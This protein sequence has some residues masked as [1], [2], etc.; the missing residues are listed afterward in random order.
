MMEQRT[1][2][3]LDIDLVGYALGDIDA[4]ST[5]ELD[6]HL[7]Q[8]LLCRV[9]LNRIRR[10]GLDSG[11]AALPKLTYPEIA[12]SILEVV[13]GRQRPASYGSGQLWLA[14]SPL[15]MLVWVQA[16][17][18]TA[19]MATV[20]ASTLD[21]DAADHTSLIVDVPRLGR[22]AAIFAS[23]PGWI[24]LDRLDIFVDDVDVSD[25]IVQLQ[26]SI[27]QPIEHSDVGADATARSGARRPQ[28][29]EALLRVGARI[30]GGS[31]E[32][33]EFRQML[34]DQLAELDPETDNDDLVDEPL[35]DLSE[36]DSIVARMQTEL[37]D[38]I[39][40]KRYGHCE[41]KPIGHD[42][43]V[44]SYAGSVRLV[45]TVHELDCLMLV[46]TSESPADGSEFEPEDAYQL[47]LA[48]GASSL[49][50]AEPTEPYLTRMYVLA[51]L[52]PAFE[53]PCATERRDP[54][55]LSKSRPLSLAVSEYLQ[56]EVFPIESDRLVLTR[57]QP[58]LAEFLPAQSLAAIVELKQ[59]KAQKGKHRALKA[60]G[61]A[62]AEALNDAIA[63]SPHLEALLARIEEITV[64]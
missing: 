17:N 56:G 10:G 7:G 27:E 42:F 32:R 21:V 31:D 23:V 47:L 38:D 24:P 64:Q 8:C 33:L 25:E 46:V 49:A 37:A 40:S 18:A 30:S 1:T 59:M 22:T 58:D 62:D 54:R 57:S 6:Q 2:H 20:L 4:A 55:P 48:S 16:V 53:P 3:P 43:L 36:F 41:V 28:K 61:P 60:L 13:G 9:H 12:P 44:G 34:A 15:R 26:Q 52:R 5:A 63:T 50:V 14:G 29:R 51:G 11:L 35:D 45:A 19:R 39:S